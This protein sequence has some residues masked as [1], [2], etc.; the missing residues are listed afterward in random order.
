MSR[1]LA[2][3]DRSFE[4][5]KISFIS[6]ECPMGFNSDSLPKTQSEWVKN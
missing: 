2:A 3:T 4:K 6:Y 5:F 1:T